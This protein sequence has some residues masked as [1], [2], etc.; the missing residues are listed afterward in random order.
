MG[1]RLN[2]TVIKTVWNKPVIAVAADKWT[3]S[4]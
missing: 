3:S 1:M 4:E 2:K